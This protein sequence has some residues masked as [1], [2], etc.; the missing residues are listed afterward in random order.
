MDNIWPGH[1]QM[2]EDTDRKP[3]GQQQGWRFVVGQAETEN[4]HNLQYS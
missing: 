1:D 3:K 2:P 4:V